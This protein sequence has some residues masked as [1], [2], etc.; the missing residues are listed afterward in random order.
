LCDSTKFTYPL[1]LDCSNMAGSNSSVCGGRHGEV[2]PPVTQAEF[3]LTGGGHE[4]D[5]Q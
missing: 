1:F 3:P 4:E 2:E 5:I